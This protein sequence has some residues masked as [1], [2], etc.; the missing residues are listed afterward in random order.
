MGPY[1]PIFW[2]FIDL[3]FTQIA[4]IDNRL[5]GSIVYWLFKHHTGK[6]F[7]RPF[8]IGRIPCAVNFNPEFALG[9][10]HAG[11][12]DFETIPGNVDNDN[13]MIVSADTGRRRLMNN[14]PRFPTF[15]PLWPS[16]KK[17]DQ[18]G[19]CHGQNCIKSSRIVTQKLFDIGAVPVN[20]HRA[21][22][23]VSRIWF[24]RACRNRATRNPIKLSFRRFNRSV[25]FT[26][27]NNIA[28][29]KQFKMMKKL[30]STIL[31]VELSLLVTA[32]FM[33]HWCLHLF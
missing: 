21:H 4:L 23:R 2:G 31:V 16:M 20:D 25:S 9:I 17:I 28:F 18:C 29:G 14:A 8:Y 13:I 1:L 32:V 6:H 11:V 24:V 33:A 27:W 22:G 3:N 7:I 10:D 26:F 15:K 12:P 5:K 19:D 30:L